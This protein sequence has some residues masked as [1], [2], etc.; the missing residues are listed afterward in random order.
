MSAPDGEAKGQ[1]QVVK[2]D[3]KINTVPGVCTTQRLMYFFFLSQNYL[4]YHQMVV[5]SFNLQS[6]GEEHGIW[7]MTFFTPEPVTMVLREATQAGY[8]A[9]TT[10][11][12]VVVRS[13]YNTAETY[14][15]DVSVHSPS[16][17][18]SIVNCTTN[19]SYTLGC[20]SSYGGFE[21]HCLLQDLSWSKCGEHG[22]CLSHR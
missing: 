2:D 22:C 13:P 3:S 17:Y 12:R 19:M 4:T 7:K 18:T 8:S 6:S 1:T 15:E 5:F 10:S 9:M 21:G 11:N 14:S 16:L 20:W